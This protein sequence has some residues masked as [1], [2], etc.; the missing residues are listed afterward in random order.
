MKSKKIILLCVVIL[1]SV[2]C[3]VP[4][5]YATTYTSGDYKYE[6][7]NNK[8]KIVGYEGSNSTVTIPSKIGNYAVTEIGYNAFNNC[9]EIETLN[10]PTSIEKIDRYAFNGCNF[11][12]VKFANDCKI[13]TITG[14]ENMNNL[15]SINIPSKVKIIG[16]SVFSNDTNLTSITIPNSVEKIEYCA[17]YNCTGLTTISI[18]TNVSDI[19]EYAFSDCNFTTVKFADDCKITSFDGF[20]NMSNLVSINIPNRVRKIESSAFA[21]D[22]KLTTI[23]IPESVREIG[24]CVFYK[25]TGLKTIKIPRRVEKIDEY[26]FTGCDFNTVVFDNDCMITEMPSFRD[27]KNLTSI[28]IPR[29]VKSLEGSVFSNVTSLRSLIIPSSVT[30]IGYSTFYGCKNLA[31]QIPKSVTKIDDYAFYNATGITVKC[32]SGSTA[33]TFCSSK[34]ITYSIITIPATKTP[35]EISKT[36]ITGYGAK[37]YTG[38]EITANL[39]VKYNGNT[40]KVGTDYVVEYDNN[41]N[42]GNATITIV[43]FGDY[44]G[45]V[46]KNFKIVPATVT[47]VKTAT[48]TT[49][50]V[51][52]SWNKNSGNISGYKVYTYDASSKLY[53]Q[54][55]TTS[56]NSYKITGLKAG[57]T[58]RYAVKAYYTNGGTTY[59][60]NDYSSILVTTTTPAKVTISKNTQGTNY[61]TVEWKKVSGATGY[62][63]YMSTSKNTNYSKIATITNAN[64]LKY[65]KTKLTAGKTYYFKV[66]AYRTV[67]GS[68]YYG[69]Y[70]SILT[71]TTK[72]KTPTLSKLTTGKKTMTVKLKKVSGASGYQVQYS[73]NKNFKKDNKST[74][75]SKSKT[76]KTINKLTSKKR[77]YVRIRAYRTVDGKKIYSC[78][79]KVKN[80]TVK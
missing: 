63:V 1:I 52:L 3:F 28:N 2:L 19:D 60:S 27:M 18:P 24:Y 46:Q 38:K 14:F 57:T 11:S 42:V 26:A 76:S 35:I 43:G 21:N 75:I 36:A 58:Y 49:S 29:S 22:T 50:E 23:T 37:P 79:S 74:N 32:E 68:T 5:T 30:T 53:N 69:P 51:T 73:T 13:T 15:T 66:R 6:V 31:I 20:Q 47:G 55:A 4:K 56:G 64:T 70:S 44:I 59:T 40:L 39:V 34:G 77:Y 65:K 80:V 67:G 48:T 33:Q 10:I 9:E 61:I 41:I 54:I 45:K 62:E 12:T 8:A 72:T 71:T 16:N 78:W 25:C 17:F 7:S